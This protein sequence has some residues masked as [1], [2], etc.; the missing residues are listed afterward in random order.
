M[1]M[2]VGEALKESK[3]ERKR[4]KAREGNHVQRRGYQS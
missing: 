4:G 1:A 2:L 3:K